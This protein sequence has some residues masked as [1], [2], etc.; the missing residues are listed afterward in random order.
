MGWIEKWKRCQER[1]L[2]AGGSARKVVRPIRG[3]KLGS[4]LG[5]GQNLIL[6]GY[7]RRSTIDISRIDQ[8]IVIF[9]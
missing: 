6:S 8:S 1:D 7:D 2:G 4:D 5:V 3:S 9:Y